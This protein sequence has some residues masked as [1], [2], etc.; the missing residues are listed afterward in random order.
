MLDQNLLKNLFYNTFVR[1]LMTEQNEMIQDIEAEVHHE[2]II[3]TKIKTPTQDRVLHL[4]IDSVMTKIQLLHN[5]H[6]HNTTIINEI[7]DLTDHLTGHHTD[8]FIDAILVPDRDHVHIHEIIIFNGI[9]LLS[10]H[11]Q[12]HDTLGFL[13]HGHIHILVINLTQ[14]NHKHRMIPLTSKYACITL[15]RRLMLS[16]LQVGFTL[17]IHTPSNQIQQDYPSRSEISFLLDSGASISVLNYPTYVTIAKLLN[18]KHTN[19]LNPPKTLTIANQTEVPIFYYVT[20]LLNTSIEDNS[21]QFTIPFAV[22]DIKY[23]ILGTPSFEEYLQNINISD[24]TLKF[25]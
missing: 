16:H 8:L 25:K 24:F 4:E 3:I 14:F 15:L 7:Q 21:R 10:D 19:T 1:L 17:C 9:L 11:L 5:S 13:D 20:I 22:A 23:N 18:I 12:D 2:T 6:D